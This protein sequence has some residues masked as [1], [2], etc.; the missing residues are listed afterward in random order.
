MNIDGVTNRLIHEKSP[1]LLQHARNPVDWYPWGN[2][3]FAKAKEENKPIFLSIGYSTCHW[4]HVMEKESF[5][6]DEVARTLNTLYVAVKVDREERP[7]I[8]HIYVMAAQAMTGRGGWPLTVLMDPEGKPFYAATYLPK[9]DRPG[10]TGLM[11]LL[12]RASDLWQQNPEELTAAGDRFKAWLKSAETSIPQPFPENTIQHALVQYQ[13]RFDPVY[14][15][16]S[17]APK[18]PSPQHLLFLLR[19]YAAKGDAH[20]LHMVTTTLDAMAR[21]GIYDAIGYGFSR[22]ATDERWLVPHFEKM[23]YDNAL[24]I[25]VY[26]EAWQVTGS[27]AYRRIAEKIIEYVRRDMTDSDGGFYSAE[28]ADSEGEEGLFYTWTPDEI[29]AVL[30]EK[31]G[32]RFCREYGITSNGHIDGRSIPNRLNQP[33]PDPA[34]PFWKRS[35]TLLF[36]QRNRRIHPFK[37]DKILTGWNGLM[38]AALSTA[39]RVFNRP[40]YLQMAERAWSFIRQNLIREDGRLLARYRDGEAGIPAFLDDYAYLSWGL[41]ELFLASSKSTYLTSCLSLWHDTERLFSS[42]SGAFYLYGS[43]SEELLSRPIHQWDGALPS[44]NGV[45]LNNLVRI[46][47]IT[48]RSD[49]DDSIADMFTAFGASI[50]QQPMGYAS[51][52]SAYLHDTVP[53]EE[54]VIALPD[55]RTPDPFLPLL[56]REYRPFSAAFTIQPENEDLSGISPFLSQLKCI[57]HQPTAYLCRNHACSQPVTSADVFLEMVRTSVDSQPTENESDPLR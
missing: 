32:E 7:D 15:G 36:L 55:D 27:E 41:L 48:G 1:Y 16:F 25:M 17:P 34:D 13:E 33:E 14:G 49:W 43:D 26:A 50:A 12:V 8:D 44:G 56:P 23:L 18:F 24:L 31:D 37:D 21:G 38:I 39:A 6:D 11:T 19:A 45:I 54:M 30:G 57:D 47:Q 10:I 5:E 4:C 2:E 20:I 51:A 22:Y 28:D 46:R 42:P 3:A 40:D 53:G 35:R 52:L 29:T 9:N